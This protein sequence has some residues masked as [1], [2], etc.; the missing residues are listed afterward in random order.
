MADTVSYRP[1]AGEI[2]TSP[3]RLPL[4][5]RDRPRALRRQGKEP[6]L[7][8]EQLFRT[9]AHAAPAHPA[10]GHSAASVEWTVVGNEFEALQLE[11]TWIN[12]F[13][14]P[15][16]VQFRDDKSYPYLAITLQE[17]VPRVLVTR[18][19]K[20]PGDAVF[21]AVLPRSG[22]SGRPSTR[23]SR[24]SRCAAAPTP[25]TGVP[26]D[27]SAVPARR[28]RQVRGPVR[29]PGDHKEDHKSIAVD[30]ASFMSGNDSKFMAR[31]GAKMKSASPRPGLRV[32]GAVSATSSAPCRRQCRRTRWCSSE[33][34]DTDFFGIAH[35]ELAAAVQQFI[36]RGGRIRGVQS[37]VVDKELDVELPE[38]VETIIAERLRATDLPPREIVVPGA[39]GRRRRN[40]NSGSATLRRRAARRG[41][42]TGR[43]SLKTPSAVRRPRWRRRSQRTRKNALDALQDAAQWRL[44][45]ALPGPRRHPGRA[46]TCPKHRCEWS[47]TTYPT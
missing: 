43:V 11:F 45:G 20:I 14:P 23:C 27:R 30:F 47:A 25:P 33:D 9:A 22:P 29:R 16:N 8:T 26:A 12:E 10:H 3:G 35:D 5:R 46:R 17:D 15:F 44:H 2:P 24:L 19:R 38:L 42:A 34:I 39:A 36:V 41:T 21:R 28:Y 40:W 1:K 13:D 6:A 18:N 37:W 32:R 31:P 4:S 7:S